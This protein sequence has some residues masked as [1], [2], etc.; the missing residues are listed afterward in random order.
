MDRAKRFVRERNWCE[1]ISAYRKIIHAAP[2]T[3]EAQF[4]LVRVCHMAGHV[5]LALKEY[6]K[7]R[8]LKDELGPNYVF[9]LDSER[10]IGELREK[11]SQ[12][13]THPRY[14]VEDRRPWA[15][16]S[17][18]VYKDKDVHDSVVVTSRTRKHG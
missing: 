6:H 1:A 4:Q 14:R 18:F 10:A 15:H 11:V 2:K 13:K 9:V 7:L 16:G 8:D 12:E 17:I 5:G 3:H